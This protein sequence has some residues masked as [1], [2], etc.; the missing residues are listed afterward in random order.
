M[1][2]KHRNSVVVTGASSGIG[3]ACALELDRAGYQVF[4][5]HA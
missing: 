3:R 1:S 4:G 5:H 2:I